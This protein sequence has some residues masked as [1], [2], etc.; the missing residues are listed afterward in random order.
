MPHASINKRRVLIVDDDQG[1]TQMLTMLLAIKGYDVKIAA[2]GR[3]AISM[4]ASMD[5]D[6]I[7]L[8]LLLPDLEGFEVCRRLKE[9]KSTHHIPI[10]I[11]SARYLFED[12][13]EG[14]YLGADDYLTKPFEHEELFA[15]MEAVMRRKSFLS[16]DEDNGDGSSVIFELRKI[17]DG[18]L[19]VPFFQPIYLLK[20][21]RLLGVEVLSRPNTETM[22]A[23]PEL[24]FRAALQFGCYCDLE[25]V[26]WKKALAMLAGSLREEKIFL[27]CN[28]YLLEGPVF[29]KIQSMF[30]EHHIAR[31][32]VVLEITERSAI[33]DF[34]AFYE[35][36]R[37][38]R[39]LGFQIAVDDV[40]GGYA[41]L[42]SIVEIRPQ[43]VKI[44]GH[45]VSN[46]KKDAFKR[47]I[48]KF[49]VSFC[50][51][52]HVLSVAE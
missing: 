12:K 51:E 3:Q 30:D 17:I 6:L 26:V 47:S 14:L 7:L 46:L 25:V 37:R 32:N 50:K 15:R 11:L 43:V 18:G 35:S 40:G 5:C 36:M 29:S 10:I 13:V 48:I 38:Y 1:V 24:L 21:P 2:S 27:N 52:R 49:L 23:N 8:D 45:I 44:D 4:A 33:S 16:F 9:E 22:L 42:E 31:K 28:P 19:V 20:P 41:S 39:E 34:K